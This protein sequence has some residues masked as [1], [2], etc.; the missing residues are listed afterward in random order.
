MP[1]PEKSPII[2]PGPLFELGAFQS[3]L[4]GRGGTIQEKPT[5]DNLLSQQHSSPTRHMLLDKDPSSQN[6]A[7]QAPYCVSLKTELCWANTPSCV[8]ETSFSSPLGKQQHACKKDSCGRGGGCWSVCF[9]SQA[10]VGTAI[11]TETKIIIA[12]TD[13]ILSM[14]LVLSLLRK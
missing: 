2:L 11:A 7:T 10:L 8:Q 13:Y 6:G 3:N 9:L 12:S 1:F 14:S 5:E 4:G